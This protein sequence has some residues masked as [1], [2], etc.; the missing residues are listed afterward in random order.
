MTIGI[1]Q[2]GA[3]NSRGI[4]K[5]LPIAVFDHGVIEFAYLK[6]LNSEALSEVLGPLPKVA[7]KNLKIALDCVL[8]LPRGLRRDLRETMAS[9][10]NTQGFGREPARK[11]FAS[12]GGGR[13]L[14]RE[15]EILAK[16]NSVFRDRPFQ[17][18][19]QTGTFRLWKDLSEDPS[20]FD[21]PFVE[22]RRSGCTSI[23]EAYPSHSWRTFLGSP[24]RDPEKL[25]QWIQKSG[26]DCRLARDW[27][28]RVMKDP[29]LADAAVIALHLA[30]LDRNEITRQPDTEGWILGF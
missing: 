10:L 1:D 29:N 16:A 30:S 25:S 20:W 27:K 3:V 28:T 23:F 21:L 19:I 26:F 9:S 11:F 4:P 17:K 6:A 22:K 14:A 2:T 24:K 12:V 13:I 7:R 15:I 8:G 5:P 18:N